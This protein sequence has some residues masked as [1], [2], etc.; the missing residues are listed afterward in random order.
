MIDAFAYMTTT[1]NGELAF[2]WSPGAKGKSVWFSQSGSTYTAKYGARETLERDGNIWRVT[3]P[4]GTVWEF[5]AIDE[6]VLKMTTA[7]GEVTN[8]IHEN[9]RIAEKRRSVNGQVESRVYSYNTDGNVESITLY[10]GTDATPHATAVRRAEFGYYTATVT[11]QGNAGDLKSLTILVPGGGTAWDSVSTR[12]FR[13]YTST[14]ANYPGG[15]KYV[16]GPAS[17]ATLSSP[18]SASDGEIAAIADIAYDYESGSRRVNSVAVNG[19]TQAMTVVYTPNSGTYDEDDYNNWALKTVAT[20]PDG[21]KRTVYAN[22]LGQDML[23]DLKASSDVDAD[24]WIYYTQ[25]DDNYARQTL[26]AN[27]SAINMAANPPYNDAVANLNV[28]LNASSGLQELTT[29]Y[30]STDGPTGKVASYLWK[31]EVREGNSTTPVL[32]RDFTYKIYT[33]GTSTIYP[34][35]KATVYREDSGGGD[36]V[37]TEY[38]YDLWTS[39]VQIKKVTI[40]LPDVGSSDQNGGTWLEGNT[41]EQHYDIQG[42]LIK[43]VDARSTETTYTY[44]DVTGTMTQ[45]VQDP[46]GLNIVTDYE[47][48][49]MGR[50][51]KTIGPAHDVNG[52]QVRSVNWTVYRDAAHEV[53]SASGYETG[54]QSWLINPVQITKM[55]DSGRV[56]DEIQAVRGSGVYDEG[57][58]TAANSFAQ[59]T[60]TRWTHH[61]LTPTG[62][63]QSTSVYHLIPTMDNDSGSSGT[64]YDQT[65]FGYDSMGRQNYVKSPG[66]TITRMVYDTRGL[67]LSSYVGTN[68]TGASQ[69][70][71]SNGGT[72]PNNMLP[73]VLNEFDNGQDGHDGLLTQ[74]TR[75]VDTNSANDRDTDYAYDWRDRLISTTID[76][77]T[78]TFR[79]SLLLDNLGR[80][81]EAYQYRE[82]SPDAL[83]AQ[84]AT[85]YDNRGRVYRTET[86]GIDDS[87]SPPVPTSSALTDNTWYDA[88]GNVIKSQPVGGESFTKTTYDRLNRP[89]IAYTGYYNSGSETPQS[90]S[91]D[92]IIEQVETEYDE[93]SIVLQ[94]ESLARYRNASGNGE[95]VAG[96]NARPS[97]T[98]YYFDEIGRQVASAEYGNQGDDEEWFDRP[99]ATPTAADSTMYP[100]VGEVAVLVSQTVY[101]AAGE[102]EDQI[103]P[104]IENESTGVTTTQTTRTTYDDVGRVTNVIKNYGSNPTEEVVTAYTPDGRVATVTAANS[105]T[106]PQVTTYN[107]GVTVPGG[108]QIASSLLL[109]SV[110]YPVGTGSD[111]TVSYQYN[112]QGQTIQMTDQNDT[113]HDY[114]YDLLGRLVTDD[115]TLP[116]G[117]TVD[118]SVLRILREYDDQLRLEK[119]ISLSAT[120]GGTQTSLVQ[121]EYDDFS[122]VNVEHQLHGASGTPPTV[123]YIYSEGTNNSDRLKSVTYPD[124]KV[125]VYGYGTG[126]AAQLSRVEKLTWNSTEVVNY[127]FLGMSRVA[128]QTYPETLSITPAVTNTLDSG[129]D[130]TYHGLDR[131]GRIVNS[132]W[133]QNSTDLVNLEYT[134]DLASNRRYRYDRV[135]ENL[136][137]PKPYDEYCGYDLLNRLQFMNRANYDSGSSPSLFQYF[138]LDQTGNWEQFQ[139]YYSEPLIQT[140]THN[141][142][143][144]ITNI[145]ETVGDPW[146]TP[147]YDSNGNAISFPQPK[148]LDDSYS[149]KYD[150]WNRLVEVK[151]DSTVVATYSYDGLNRRTTRDDSTTLTHFY[152]NNQWQCVEERTGSSTT[153]SKQYVWGIQ[154]IDD[155][156]LSDDVSD[157]YYYCQDANFNVVAALD[158][159]GEVQERY[160]YTPY[161]VVEYLNDDFT[162]KSTGFISN[163]FLYTG[164]R[165]DPETGLQYSR[166]RYYHAQLGRWINRDPIGYFG[167]KWNLYEYVGG[168]PTR[169]VDP[170][171]RITWTVNEQACTIT[172]HVKVQVKFK[173]YGGN[174]WTQQRQEEFLKKLRESIEGVF[175]NPKGIGIHP[176]MSNVWR[177]TY[178]TGC[179]CFQKGFTPHVVLS[180]VPQGTSS[181]SEDWSIG[182]WANPDGDF[183]QSSNWGSWGYLDEDDVNPT[184]KP[185]A[186]P[187]HDQNPAAHEFGHFLGLDH[188]GEGLWSSELSEGANEYTHVG[189]D[190]CGNSV[191]GTIDLMGAGDGLR[192]FYYQKW[193][194]YLNK[195]Y[196]DCKY[197]P[198]SRK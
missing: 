90:V 11:N 153:A 70:D 146:P 49:D 139:Q 156:V 89:E 116:G 176:L 3:E 18:D 26:R 97:F 173:D 66:G 51:T 78:D 8:Y 82:G 186:A 197:K 10:R 144:E 68:D 108:S 75:P 88:V 57:A 135:A 158:N 170:T 121:Y 145:T 151:E 147:G 43:S 80:T 79:T 72:S 7:G 62:R 123:E 84:G 169:Y 172:M 107:Y 101:N 13:Y 44:S 20:M 64:N 36:P 198:K 29:Y 73:V 21:S 91:T 122:R 150:A 140:R 154:Y 74:A 155:L 181:I 125:L 164:R 141:T 102:S 118:D 87:V 174:S 52:V 81:T 99:E 127:Q 178:T 130:D 95:L 98:A 106:G 50:Q 100:A 28:Q 196:H 168:M 9:N 85:H 67:S 35:W 46:T 171:G 142:A 15:L 56:T 190:D 92:I 77:G 1:T 6:L 162:V 63:L 54:S 129:G 182:V 167:S 149:A 159:T 194:D 58:L 193:A 157:R 179:P 180:F 163:E 143:N 160:A 94:T 34:I 59:L 41:E 65:N 17:Y 109:G 40:D 83:I 16:V 177:G 71:P 4:N 30:Q 112:R 105:S 76:D 117:S 48:D 192:A 128:V 120:S 39:T 126:T 189:E 14:G 110:V 124:D 22:H 38:D 165:L 19:G 25:Y 138:T 45:M 183:V 24:R 185:G 161:G 188:P 27:P 37:T 119:V 93:A 55:D 111:R 136:S 42:R 12:Y 69:S 133:K 103:V 134:Y 23:V 152:Y 33:E 32:L 184:T 115:V 96:D 114:T 187:G 86:W 195:Y 191:D 132:L 47:S 131:F 60:W 148:D 137:T 53:Y 175:D 104:F 61:E 166:Y 113:V 31:V 2:V 5:D